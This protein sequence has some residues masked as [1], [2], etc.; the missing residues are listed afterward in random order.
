VPICFCAVQ[1]L[2]LFW[3]IGRTHNFVQ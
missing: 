3:F 2:A 1:N